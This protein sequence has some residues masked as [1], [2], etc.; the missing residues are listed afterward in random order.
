[1]KRLPTILTGLFLAVTL[2]RV[3]EFVDGKMAAGALGWLFAAGLGVAVY[4]ASYWTR[5]VITRR[6]AM[7]ALVFFVATD[8]YLNFAEVWLA[9][10]TSEP[11]VAVGAV[12]YG[13]FPTVAVALLGW[14]SGSIKRLPTDAQQKRS[15]AVGVALY[16]RIMR[17]LDLPDAPDAQPDAQPAHEVTQAPEPPAHVCASCG[18]VFASQ[19]ALAAHM[20]WKHP[21]KTTKGK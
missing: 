4:T 20:R 16:R 12:L 17:K 2:W 11:L 8:A 7:V 5:A 10:D 1:M 9:A 19:Q 14:L 21:T 15:N 13:L 18:K 6:P 3:A